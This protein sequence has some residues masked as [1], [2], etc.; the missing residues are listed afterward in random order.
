MN[1]QSTTS[2]VTAVLFAALIVTSG[3]LAFIPMPATAATGDVVGSDTFGEQV[4]NVEIHDDRAYVFGQTKM[5]VYDISDPSNPTEL[6]STSLLGTTF[7]VEIDGKDGLAFVA[8][9]DS[10]S[11][12]RLSVYDVSDPS[13]IQLVDSDA[14]DDWRGV[15]LDRESNTAYTSVNNGPIHA[16]DYSNPSSLSLL[17]QG[18]DS[19]YG[20]MVIGPNNDYIYAYSPSGALN[21]FDVTTPSTSISQ[22]FVDSSFQSDFSGAYDGVQV[23][24][25]RLYTASD[26][27]VKAYDISDRDNPVEV[28]SVSVGSI[29]YAMSIDG[30]TMT[31][32]EYGANPDVIRYF[33]I[34]DPNSI[35]T[36]ETITVSDLATADAELSGGYIYTAPG[37]TYDFTVLD[38]QSYKNANTL[39]GTVVDESGAPVTNATVEIYGVDHSQITAA[40]GQ[41]LEER[42]QEL[43]AEA[44]D[45]Y[46]AEWDEN[47][48]I[49]SL[50]ADA[51]DDYV[52]VHSANVLPNNRFFDGKAGGASADLDTPQ[53]VVA[54]DEPIVM[55]VWDPSGSDPSSKYLDNAVDADLPGRTT[56][57][58]IVVNKLS[59]SGEVL[60]STEI[61]TKDIYETGTTPFDK[62][63]E[64][65]RLSL[66][67]G[68]YEV[69]AE[70]SS[71][72]YVIAS[73][74]DMSIE[75][76][77]NT[78]AKGLEDSANRA[79]E[80]A[81]EID[82]KLTDGTFGRV[83][84]ET[85]ANGEFAAEIP[86]A[87]TTVDVTAY[88][89]GDLLDGISLEDRSVSELQE[90]IEAMDYTASV[91]IPTETKTVSAPFDSPVSIEVK[92]VLS[93][94]N[95]GGIDTTTAEDLV[96]DTINS[97][98]GTAETIT[99]PD[100]WDN[101][102]EE[103]KEELYNSLLR[104]VIGNDNLETCIIDEAEE[105]G[106]TSDYHFDS[107]SQ[108]TANTH[109]QIM[110]SC[111][112]TTSPVDVPLPDDVE[113]GAEE[114]KNGVGDVVEHVLNLR[115]PFSG[116]LDPDTA[117]VIVRYADGSFET[118]PEDYWSVDEGLIGNDAVVIEDYPMPK[119]QP[120]VSVEILASDEDG[121]DRGS[122]D[123]RNPAFAGETPAL[124]SIKLNTIA[125]GAGQSVNLDVTPTDDSSFK[126]VKSAKV[127]DGDGNVVSSSLSNGELSFTA[128]PGSHLV[129]LTVEDTNGNE[130][131]ERLRI[132][133]EDDDLPYDP[134]I[135][136]QKGFLGTY[137]VVG[138]GA[139]DGEISQKND[140]TTVGVVLAKGESPSAVRVHLN[141]LDTT[142]DIKVRLMQGDD[143][144]SYERFTTVFVYTSQLSEDSLVYRN[145]DEPIATEKGQYGTR[146]D[147]ADSE[148]IVTYTETDG[149]VD[150]SVNNNPGIVDRTL[151]WIR[152]N[153]GSYT[154]GIFGAIM[155]PLPAL[156]LYARRR[157]DVL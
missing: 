44:K 99:D 45:P 129:K 37:T 151:F 32:T 144:Q 107:V 150:L 101:A 55:T 135:R 67:Q 35:T 61:E 5:T 75:E 73:V 157:G 48:D 20:R 145:G 128:G 79:T 53:L 93:L 116:S 60:D 9:Y 65:A 142:G 78:Y 3:F 43:L 127:W 83:V 26:T 50:F 85:D 106:V 113:G 121:L 112:G 24:G 72:S 41:S 130:Y 86:A 30:T 100:A 91:Y 40:T 80:R 46:P 88:K 92:E 138:D 90:Q 122:V 108:D 115:I 153:I 97:T 28:S 56:D 81:N 110:Q 139:I 148:L 154:S 63:H 96:N 23:S 146:M 119:D 143:E 57:G 123:V 1:S 15:A 62:M 17:G 89:G 109:I 36:V 18:T 70:G 39:S 25:E 156:G 147:K 38:S 33:D 21:I 155:I 66:G 7:D 64:G 95:T 141:E 52:A 68:F 126:S 12:W 74:G 131:V 34:S 27:A 118:M 22:V 125:P 54:A 111:L 14:T 51:E 124:K 47:L 137:A 136:V 16:F 117:S 102:T 82:Q 49:L 42:A 6:G 58:T 132:N 29:N 133:A 11:I 10:S 31:V 8:E 87:F 140:V 76:M 149:T 59:M 152:L 134:S 2:R 69:S 13:N 84:V 104:T 19:I 98:Q 77:G 114:V 120:M 105:A 71:T 103:A 4:R 94:P